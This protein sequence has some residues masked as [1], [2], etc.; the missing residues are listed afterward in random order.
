M[1]C[2]QSTTPDRRKKLWLV[3]SLRQLAPSLGADPRYGLE[4]SIAERSEHYN[5]AVVD[6]A[7]LFARGI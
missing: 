3:F 4:L 1:L 6:I 5:F 2:L 7:E